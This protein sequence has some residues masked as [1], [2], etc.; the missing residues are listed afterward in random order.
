MYRN[1]LNR[2]RALFISSPLKQ[3]PQ[4][5]SQE[6]QAEKDDAS[7]PYSDQ[8]ETIIRQG[9]T[10]PTPEFGAP[11]LVWHVGIWPRRHVKRSGELC[12]PHDTFSLSYAEARRAYDIRSK[13]WI[14]Q[15]N[16]L[17]KTLQAIG[18]RP[19]ADGRVVPK[20][21]V[22]YVP[23]ELAVLQTAD[24]GKL[25][26][27]TG[28]DEP[29]QVL[30]NETI[31]FTMWW[32]DAREEP[33]DHQETAI[34]IRVQV[35]LN[36]DYAALSFYMDL[37]QHWNRPR[38]IEDNLKPGRRRA[39]AL[40]AVDD[41]KRICE[42]QL[43][44]A[45]SDGVAPVDWPALP[46][47]LA[48][49]DDRDEKQL[50]QA[51]MDARNLLYVDLWEDFCTDF[52][53]SLDVIAGGRGEVFANFRGLVLATDGLHA[54]AEGE[55][56]R[57]NHAAQGLIGSLG[58]V[59]FPTFDP[60]S[61]EPNA[62][63]KAFWPFLRRI[64]PGADYR[65]FTA[66]GV[67]DWRAL[68]ITALGSSSQYSRD[69]ERAAAISD[70][71]EDDI[72]SHVRHDN[73]E[74]QE[75]I[76][77]QIRRRVGRYGNN[78]PVRYLFLTKCDPHPRQIGRIVERINTMGTL[79]LFA[80][81]DWSAIKDADPFI[82]MLGQELDQT[83]RKWSIK[84][85]KIEDWASIGEIRK[86]KANKEFPELANLDIPAGLSSYLRAFG[87]SVLAFFAGK[88]HSE[89]LRKE[90]RDA[91]SDLKYEALYEVT[92][93]IET[94][95]INISARLDHIGSKC[96]GGLHFRLN[97]STYYVKEFGILLE[98]LR[99]GNIPTWVAY[100]QFVKRGLAPAFDYIAS[101]GSRLRAL[102]DRLQS[103]TEAIETSALVVQSAATRHNTAV[104]RR[105]MIVAVILV[106]GVVLRLLALAFPAAVTVLLDLIQ[107]IIRLFS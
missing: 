22:S 20:E 61:A 26:A 34:R 70:K 44:P 9:H 79:R 67:M 87:G 29:T 19:S 81:K 103:V 88:R 69:A 107:R 38:R 52:R 58:T 27:D 76:D 86:E 74:P 30:Q 49:P 101:M 21:F 37:G 71:S 60:D 78:H 17:I 2:L 42:K 82:R 14:R 23:H 11:T 48:R 89:F 92:K 77:S 12:D 99:V 100:D 33:G 97:R 25:A 8:Y 53:C 72:I 91:L 43:T 83:T 64:T 68:Y 50:D 45:G 46:E 28:S 63:L 93:S 47:R 16:E 94:S 54:A 18:C 41:V 4:P 39:E 6:K 98:T 56:S 62:V 73:G 95:L 106:I 104:L 1:I 13:L 36:A 57:A 66:C 65:D 5:K 7:S 59:K 75:Y 80:L 32:R 102:R 55:V 84:R 40:K 105:I 51:L 10:R 15:V 90:R 31:G 85:K 35:E 24:A 3:K 96:V